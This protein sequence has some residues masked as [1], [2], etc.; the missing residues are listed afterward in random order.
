M[1]RSTVYALLAAVPDVSPTEPPGADKLT[2]I[3]GW[4]LWVATAA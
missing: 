2:T 3:L 4:V 1:F